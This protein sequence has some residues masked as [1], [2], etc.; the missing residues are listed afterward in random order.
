MLYGESIRVAYETAF[1]E[2]GGFFAGLAEAGFE[3]VPLYAAQQQASGTIT[4]ATLEQLWSDL[5]RSLEQAGQLDGLLIAAHGAAVC[6]SEHDMDGWWLSKVRNRVGDIP[7]VCTLDP[8]AN[9]SPRMIGAVDATIAYRTNPHI[10]QRERGLEAARL[11]VRTLRGE[12]KLTQAL[13]TPPL[14]I[15][16]ER[17]LTAAPPCLEVQRR[18]DAFRKL[19]GVLSVSF[20]LGFPYADVEE[21]GSSFIVVTDDDPRLAQSLADELAAYL[22]QNRT[23]FVGQFLETEDALRRVQQAAKPVCLLDMGDNIGGGSPGDGTYLASALLAK[24]VNAFVCLNDPEAVRQVEAVGSPLR[25]RM[26]GKADTL[27]G[28]PLECDVTPVSLHDGAF[29]ETEA[30]HGGDTS[31]DM[32]RTALVKAASLTV[33][34]TSKR[35]APFS[36]QQ[37]LACGVDPKSFDAIVAK[38]VH[39]PVA[40]YAPVCPT[41]LRVNTPGVTS[42]DLNHFMFRNRRRPLFPFE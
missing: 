18:A 30:R 32:G 14:A 16:I 4:S 34:L 29:Y 12:V 13:A 42:A 40:A 26:G 8:H 6:E 41:L 20:V 27:H 35:I 11:L 22:W 25:L 17:Q 1:H 31:F 21:M 28:A 2:L 39:A 19:P 33:M 24:G 36:L 37:L 10:D 23:A 5:E 7:I 9:V 3:A 15:N 38:G